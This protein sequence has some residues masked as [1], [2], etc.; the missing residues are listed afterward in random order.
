M[1]RGAHSAKRVKQHKA[2]AAAPSVMPAITATVARAT[3]RAQEAW[4]ADLV[5]QVIEELN[6][7]APVT[8]RQIREAAR[9]Q[10]RKKQFMAAGA[11]TLLAATTGSI[12][13]T[14]SAASPFA[15]SSAEDTGIIAAYPGSGKQ[16]SSTTSSASRSSERRALSETTTQ[17][18]QGNW[19]LSAD[20]SSLDSGQMSKSTV[21]NPVV[22]ARIDQA[23]EQG[24]KL[25]DGFNPNHATGDS[26]LAYEFS[27]CTWWAYTR[28]HQ[29]GLPVGSYLGNGGQW[30]TSARALGYWVDNTPQVGDIM[31]FA[32]GQDGTDP[33]YGHVAIVE[34]IEDGK[35]ITSECGAVMNGKTY[36]KT[37]TNAG[38]Y[39]YIHF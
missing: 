13:A 2:H 28:R 24:L 29:L 4:N 32:P 3:H 19:S 21:S 37:Y 23:K 39:Q 36:S 34:S 17:S 20:E 27:Q 16:S 10:N 33:L 8:R 38:N 12:F 30:A 14:T 1:T 11:F 6:A 22:A 7:A 9:Q 5:P 26:G 35:V 25:P 18:S 15:R 31:V